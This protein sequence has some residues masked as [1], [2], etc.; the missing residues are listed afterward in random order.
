[1]DLHFREEKKKRNGYMYQMV[2]TNNK[3]ITRC[4]S[5]TK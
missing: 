5:H 4:G 3:T 1:M 2:N